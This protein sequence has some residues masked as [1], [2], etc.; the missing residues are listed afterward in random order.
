MGYKVVLD[1]R[2][3]EKLIND[4]PGR[5]EKVLDKIAY[6]AQADIQTS[7]SNES[8]SLAGDPPGV[9]TGNLKNN[10]R[11]EVSGPFKRKIIAATE[12]AA[13]LEF[14][15]V[16]MAARPFM[17]PAARRIMDRLPDEFKARL[18]NL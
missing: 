18:L 12:Y 16:R 4:L 2:V 8:P 6:D 17:F 13:F 9:R 10:I 7:F 11:V 14:G 3:L 1:K 15:T 5:A